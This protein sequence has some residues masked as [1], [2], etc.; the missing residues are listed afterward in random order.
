M[1]RDN[2]QQNDN[3]KV[4]VSD[5]NLNMDEKIDLT[6]EEVT[7]KLTKWW[8]QYPHLLKMNIYFGCAVFGMITLRYDGIIMSNL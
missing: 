5:V 3:V 2:E 7:P 1:K 4:L 6:L 8:F